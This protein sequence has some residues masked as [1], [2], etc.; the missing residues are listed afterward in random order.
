MDLSFFLWPIV[1]MK[2]NQMGIPTDGIDFSNIKSMDD[3][4]K[5]LIPEIVKSN[6]QAKEL[7]KQNMGTLDKST[8]DKVVEVIDSL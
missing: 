6:P 1:K 5:K 2:L 3:F 7:I 8:Q 4:A